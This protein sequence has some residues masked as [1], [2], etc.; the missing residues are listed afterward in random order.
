MTA[1]PPRRIRSTHGIG[2]V[3]CIPA[4]K[5]IH[6]QFRR[7]PAR[8]RRPTVHA[9][10]ATWSAG[11]YW[12]GLSFTN[13]SVYPSARGLHSTA[14]SSSPLTTQRTTEKPVDKSLLLSGREHVLCI[15]SPLGIAAGPHATRGRCGCASGSR[16]SRRLASIRSRAGTLEATPVMPIGRLRPCG[17]GFLGQYG[18]TPSPRALST[19]G[20]CLVASGVITT[21]IRGGTYRR[22]PWTKVGLACRTSPLRVA[23]RR[24]SARHRAADKAIP[25][26]MR[27]RNAYVTPI[28]G[29][30]D[31][32]PKVLETA[33]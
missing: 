25:V 12:M 27:V 28:P 6:S 1:R 7:W 14:R 24:W 18:G 4:P 11:N 2:R 21:F 33:L 10:A 26:A 13:A 17:L 16:G 29:E 23:E 3:R 8:V 19:D 9:Q 15:G 22:W 20:C 32:L 31:G 30:P 5:G